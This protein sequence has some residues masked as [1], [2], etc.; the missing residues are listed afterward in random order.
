MLIIIDYYSENPIVGKTLQSCYLENSNV[1]D[2]VNGNGDVNWKIYNSKNIIIESDNTYDI[3]INSDANVNV[4][5]Q[6]DIQLLSNKDVNISGQ[7]NIKQITN[8]HYITSSGGAFW[9]VK[10]FIYYNVF[11]PTIPQSTD[12]V[13]GDALYPTTNAVIVK[14]QTINNVK[15]PGGSNGQVLTTDGSGNLSWTTS[16]SSGLTASSF[17]FNEVPSPTAIVNNFTI[18]FTP[19]ANTIQ[20]F[21]NGLLQKPTTDYTV[22]GTTIIFVNFPLLT[23]EILCHYIKA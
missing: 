9:N 4:Y 12:I 22:S 16:S 23:D 14:F 6:D 1:Y 2:D 18:A 21:I 8:Q 19:V 20:V 13:F 15:I 7:N 17:V 10:N 3:D 11:T 5:S